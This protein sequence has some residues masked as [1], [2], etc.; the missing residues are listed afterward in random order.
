MPRPDQ[1]NAIERIRRA[2][3]PKQSVAA[4][5]IAGFFSICGIIVAIPSLSSAE[6]KK[7]ELSI[8]DIFG[9]PP[10][11]N[12][13]K[14]SVKKPTI[15]PVEPIASQKTSTPPIGDAELLQPLPSSYQNPPTTAQNNTPRQTKPQPE[16]D[17]ASI[18]G[19]L[20]G[21]N[22]KPK[23]SPILEP[24]PV[25]TLMP[26]TASDTIVNPVP[27]NN[28]KEPSFVPPE[29]I[30]PPAPPPVADIP[31]IAPQ[32]QTSSEPGMLPEVP[33]IA[34]EATP[35]IVTLQEPAPK[36][37]AK[38]Q[39][40][41]LNQ[42]A[43]NTLTQLQQQN[44]SPMPP[45]QG[46]LWQ[47][48][49]ATAHESPITDTTPTNIIP[50]LPA[51]SPVMLRLEFLPGSISLAPSTIVAVRQLANS[52]QHDT[53]LRLELHGF[54]DFARKGSLDASR[55]MGGAR[56]DN[57]AKA[58][59]EF[60]VDPRRLNVVPVGLDFLPG[61]ARDRVDVVGVR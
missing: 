44:E 53:G 45:N 46:M 29:V 15:T 41:M 30:I 60:G 4:G 50:T 21:E 31:F 52:M 37:T 39:P 25:R 7:E 22:N 33:V 28:V 32:Q 18:L 8:E 54:G 12:A 43:K 47:A 13:A 48:P 6:N 61:V 58:L 49:I 17:S 35:E 14:E 10:P 40:P 3:T 23:P 36:P 34:N 2:L 56:A 24:E 38:K 55:R 42:G 1:K 59:Q 19:N 9:V 26:S 5:F 57:V 20:F 16:D 51:L 11:S 27:Q